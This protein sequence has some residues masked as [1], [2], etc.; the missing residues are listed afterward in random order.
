MFIET[1]DKS[2]NIYLQTCT[3]LASSLT[4]LAFLSLSSPQTKQ[5][6]HPQRR[7]C[8]KTFLETD[9]F[10]CICVPTQTPS[11]RLFF[12]SGLLIN[13][14]TCSAK[15][16]DVNPSCLNLIW[17]SS[18]SQ[19]QTHTNG[20]NYKHTNYCVILLQRRIKTLPTAHLANQRAGRRFPPP[21]WPVESGFLPPSSSL[22][23]E[24][25]H[26]DLSPLQTS[27]QLTLTN[28]I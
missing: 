13:K 5:K 22:M 1:F 17:S 6:S 20:F 11:A 3:R 19:Q 21:Q 18:N 4:F 16:R 23:L 28:F 15:K 25:A 9:L 7:L 10:V 2:K 12:P 27:H 26:R 14:V 8:K 24:E